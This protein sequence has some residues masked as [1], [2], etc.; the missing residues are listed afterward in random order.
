MLL[1]LLLQL[2]RDVGRKALEGAARCRQKLQS[3]VRG[4][5]AISGTSTGAVSS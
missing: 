1:L 4:Y 3:A 5:C 2:L